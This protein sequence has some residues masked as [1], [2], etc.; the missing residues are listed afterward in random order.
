[1]SLSETDLHGTTMDH[2]RSAVNS[3]SS[4][5]ECSMIGSFS[6]KPY[7]KTGGQS[8]GLGEWGDVCRPVPRPRPG[9]DCDELGNS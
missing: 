7:E 6:G 3:G 9:T 8:W 1:M 5:E 4:I 2:R